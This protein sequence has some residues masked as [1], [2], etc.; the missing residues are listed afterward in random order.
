MQLDV[1][2]DVLPAYVEQVSSN[3]KLYFFFFFF[4]STVPTFQERH[5]TW[6][7]DVFYQGVPLLM[8]LY[9]VRGLLPVVVITPKP[10]GGNLK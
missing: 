6:S 8:W 5:G 4:S 10:C 1:Q 2:V 7:L 9:R 3:S